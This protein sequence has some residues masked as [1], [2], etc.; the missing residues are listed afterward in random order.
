MQIEVHYSTR[1]KFAAELDGNV[2]T[3]R[4]M[5]EE[6]GVAE[7]AREDGDGQT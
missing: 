1:I 4:R 2:L 3:R 7:R 6:R 5:L